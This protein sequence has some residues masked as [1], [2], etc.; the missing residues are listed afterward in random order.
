MDIAAL[1]PDTAI[2]VVGCPEPTIW[3]E[4]RRAARQFC[5]DTGIWKVPFQVFAV[6]GLD[7][8]PIEPEGSATVS[9]LVW[10]GL[11]GKRLEGR[12]SE[13]MMRNQDPNA[14]RGRPTHYYWSRADDM[15]LAPVPDSQYRL[16]GVMTLIPRRS[17]MDIP[18]WLG[19]RWGEALV[20]LAA[21]W[22]LTIPGQRWTDANFARAQMAR[23]QQYVAQAKRQAEGLDQPATRVVRYGGY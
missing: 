13:V 14:E 11:D 3:V 1:T 9:S 16:E 2:H 17:A 20:A 21:A 22:L 4:L 23:Y 7:R 5:Q 8:Y 12:D 18:D 10:I 15:V 19:E 6:P